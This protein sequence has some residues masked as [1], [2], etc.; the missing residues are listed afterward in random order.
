LPANA[1]GT[2]DV[3]LG[4]FSGLDLELSP[5][6]IPEGI[7]PANND[8]VFRPG[9]VATRPGLN[10]VFAAPLTSLGPTTYQK[11]FVM[12]SGVTKNLYLTRDDGI[13]W[14]EDLA[15][16]PG[17]AVSLWQSSGSTYANSVT[18]LNA[19]YIALSDGLKGVDV[20]LYY[21]GNVL[22]RITQDGPGAPPTVTSLALPSTTL[23][24]GGTTDTDVVS[25]EPNN[26][27]QIGRPGDQY[28]LWMGLLITVVSTAD[29]VA[30]SYVQV[31]G[32]SL[33]NGTFYVSAV[34]SATQIQCS[35]G[36]TDDS[37]GLGGSLA[38]G[39]ATTLTRF[40]NKV[41]GNTSAAHNLQVGYQVQI[42]DIAASVIG[43]VSSIVI[44][45]ADNPGIATVT[46]AAAHGLQPGN[47]V[48]ITGVTGNAV[49]GGLASLLRS[50]QLVTVT[51]ASA[52][53]LEVGAVVKINTTTVGLESFNGQ[54][55]ILSVPSSTT[56]TYYQFDSDVVSTPAAGTVT[57]VW[58]IVDNGPAPNYFTV[59]TA[60]TATTFTMGISYT[61]GTWTGGSITFA[62]DGIFYVTAVPSSTS[63][64]YQQYGPNATTNVAGTVTPYGQATP[65]IHQVAQCFIFKDGSISA[66]S[67]PST[68]IANGGQYLSVIGLAI[69]PPQ[70]I[71]RLLIFTGAGGAY[72]FHIPVP[73]QVNGLTVAT[74]TQIN[75]NVSTSA[76]LDFS[77]NTLYAAIADSVPGNNLYAQN[78]LGPV[79]GLF[80]YA[81][82]LIGWGNRN[83][84]N[85]LL[86]LGF[87]GGYNASL[88]KNPLG[89]T[90]ADATGQIVSSRLGFAWQIGLNVAATPYGSIS[91]GA[92][93]KWDGSVIFAAGYQYSARFW[94]KIAGTTTNPVVW[95]RLWSPT[96][97]FTTAASAAIDSATGEFY[98]GNF[99][100]PLPATLPQDLTLTVW[101]AGTSPDATGTI[102]IDDIEL[103]PTIQP[104]IQNEAWISYATNFSG[105]DGNTGLIGPQDD[106]SAIM[107]MGVIRNTLRIITGSGLHQTNDN[108]E[109]EPDG[110]EVDQVADNC[111]AFSVAS[112]ARNAQGIGSAGKDWMAWSGP[113]GAQILVGEL[114]A[115]ISQEI[116]PLWDAIPQDLAYRCWAKNWEAAKLCFFGVPT[117]SGS[118]QVLV[119]DYRNLSGEMIGSN[120]PI[121]ISFTG[122]MIASDLTRKWTVWNIP[123]FS[124][125]LMYRAGNTSPQ[126]VF[127]CETPSG[128]AN[129]YILNPSSYHDDDFGQINWAYTTYFFV[130]HEMEQALKVGSHRKL[131]SLS[132]AFIEGV[133]KW[134]ITPL[135]ANL[136]NPFPSSPYFPLSQTQNFDV[137]FGINA[138][139]TRCAF[140]IAGTPNQGSLDSYANLQKLVINITP[141]PWAPTRGSAYGAF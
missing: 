12:P 17:I 112:V 55:T 126:I 19:E 28:T 91:Q 80:T 37:I 60:P 68:F 93:Q 77:D 7:S 129:S 139:T 72:F 71:G 36:T 11:S 58:P 87:D 127:G 98:V 33:W 89:W 40:N 105:F 125:E 52:H 1:A 57:Y 23:S 111:G 5:A 76:L 24:A 67:P 120:P 83:K 61:D 134:N 90:V 92:Y 73:A 25:A 137:D 41:S 50:A 42:S 130:S 109:T 63:F 132:Q 34:L 49:G 75:D 48:Q 6:T 78:V 121:R 119:L 102:T 88:P 97:G 96:T 31:S 14:V 66:P 114:P 13:L 128:A 2:V 131:Y 64:E 38:I 101:G 21:D 46:T 79:S 85:G 4:L 104:F 84:V 54:F 74:A 122:K 27:R 135:L 56:F 59:L 30:G 32:N 3:P 15:V 29:I 65:G 69:G 99:D 8:V 136:S 47:K 43:T 106:T 82:R 18:A 117:Q 44:A 16:N 100:L 124:G 115:K 118:M 53:G 35:F 70:V 9:S 116:Q 39:A 10:R 108:S 51:T 133:G 113:D 140:T 95:L 107:N 81:S 26:P 62:W 103:Y 86:N 110:W 141:A 138:E 123:A 45:N 20:P 22:R 94:G